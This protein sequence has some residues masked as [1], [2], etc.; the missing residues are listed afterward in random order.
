MSLI[1]TARSEGRNERHATIGVWQNGRKAGV[2][3]VETEHEQRVLGLLNTAIELLELAH[4]ARG[5]IEEYSIAAKFEHS[6]NCDCICCQL[7][8]II[9][10]AEPWR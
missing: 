4:Q 6:P 8:K 10:K 7:G 9:R 5:T 1:L 3:T 2:L